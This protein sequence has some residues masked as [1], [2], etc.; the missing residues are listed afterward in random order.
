MRNVFLSLLFL[1]VCNS[2]V[3]EAKNSLVSDFVVSREENA[4]NIVCKHEVCHEDKFNVNDRIRKD[5]TSRS[6]FEVGKGTF[7][8]NGKPFVI[9]AA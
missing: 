3:I 9:K 1:I 8:L 2:F 6:C 5:E 7:L 4:K